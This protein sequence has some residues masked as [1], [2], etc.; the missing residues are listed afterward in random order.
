[1]SAF[2]EIKQELAD[3]INSGDEAASAE[4]SQK[5]VD[6]QVE[7][8]EIFN[9]CVIPTLKVIGDRFSRMEIFLPEMMMAADA[10]KAV[11]AVLDPVLKAS[12]GG[13]LT[14]GKVVIGT[15]AGDVHDIGKNMVA[16]MLEV[17]GFEVNDLG[18]D[19]SPKTFI[20]TAKKEGADI[21]AMSSLLTTSLPYMK[22]VL[23]IVKETG[24]TSFKIMVGGGPVTAE[25]ASE[26]GAHGYGRDA[27]DAVRV[28]R[29]LVGVA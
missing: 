23:A 16:S 26:L 7:P 15:I 24:E 2:D 29:E 12:Q 25:W 6:A 5:A 3:A 9:D 8:A 18:T 19:V 27:S 14:F 28:A 10:A 20:D 1:M 17:S 22:D 4:L 13:S 21:I 11:I